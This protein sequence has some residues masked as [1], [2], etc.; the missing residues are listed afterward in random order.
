[1]SLIMGSIRVPAFAVLVLL[2]LVAT[3]SVDW[4]M[5]FLLLAVNGALAILWALFKAVR[6]PDLFW[7]GALCLGIGVY[8][9]LFK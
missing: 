2:M 1:M 8:V 5:F 9:L 3:K 6:E 4:P 7:F